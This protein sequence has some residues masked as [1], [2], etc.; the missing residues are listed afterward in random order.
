MEPLA[1]MVS[2][3]R[4]LADRSAGGGKLRE[5]GFHG[6]QQYLAFVRDRGARVTGAVARPRQQPRAQA[7]LQL[8]DL[9][10]DRRGA[11]MKGGGRAG[12]TAAAR[13]RGEGAQRRKAGFGHREF[14]SV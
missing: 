6:A 8:A 11:D 5:R 12:K 9:M 14:G 13:H 1:E 10:A 3:G 4:A 7:G 2:T